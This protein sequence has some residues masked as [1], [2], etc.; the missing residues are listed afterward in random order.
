MLKTVQGKI[1]KAVKTNPYVDLRKISA[2][3]RSIDGILMKDNAVLH[4]CKPSTD[5]D[6]AAGYMQKA[7]GAKKGTAVKYNASELP[8]GAVYMSPHIAFLPVEPTKKK[9]KTTKTKQGYSL[10][11]KKDE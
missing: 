9:A 10:G 2:T 1:V 6:T 11:K 5:S 7:K 4:F 8:D 3:S